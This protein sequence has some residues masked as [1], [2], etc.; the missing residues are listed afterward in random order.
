MVLHASESTRKSCKKIHIELIFNGKLHAI[1]P[2]GRPQMKA[3]NKRFMLALHKAT[4][5]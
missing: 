2:R 1:V 4:S 5:N 3:N